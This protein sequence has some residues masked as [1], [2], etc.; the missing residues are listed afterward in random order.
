MYLYL[1]FEMFHDSKLTAASRLAVQ[2]LRKFLFLS[3]SER[4][5]CAFV[6]DAI[7][8]KY[9]I[10]EL[11]LEFKLVYIRCWVLFK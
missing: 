5:V 7:S 8:N 3:V 10:S 6:R 1:A 11:M 9:D 2:K 4:T